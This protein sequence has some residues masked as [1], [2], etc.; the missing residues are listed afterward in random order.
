[1]FLQNSL[2]EHR[3]QELTEFLRVIVK[4][5]PG[6][7]TPAL[8]LRI[9]QHAYNIAQKPAWDSLDLGH[10]HVVEDWIT[11]QIFSPHEDANLRVSELAGR[12]LQYFVGVVAPV[13]RHASGDD[14]NI[15]HHARGIGL[16]ERRLEARLHEHCRFAVEVVLT[17]GRV[18]DADLDVR[19][20]E[21]VVDNGLLHRVGVVRNPFAGLVH[22]E[23]TVVF[24]LALEVN[25]LDLGILLAAHPAN[26][27][28]NVIVSRHGH[29]AQASK[30]LGVSYPKPDLIRCLV[31]AWHLYL[32]VDRNNGPARHLSQ[33][34]VLRIDVRV[35]PELVAEGAEEHTRGAGNELLPFSNETEDAAL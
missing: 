2:C 11:L 31:E 30:L 25:R 35:E 21:I 16:K 9:L 14:G 19:V 7:N 10:A 12:L 34:G 3:L 17:Q 29:D 4:M 27:Q 8:E 5:K 24:R 15:P 6:E 18:I 20:L 33:F 13:L 32:H 22:G 1:M 28:L 26:D 23:P